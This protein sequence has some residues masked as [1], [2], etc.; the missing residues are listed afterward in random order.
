MSVIWLTGLSGAG[1]TTLGEALRRRI[2]PFAPVALLD[3]D[4]VREAVGD[5]LGHTEADR[6]VQ[7]GRLGRFA[8]LL[9]GQ[10]IVVIVA[11]V[12]AD[13]AQLAW[14]RAHL[15]GY[16]EVHLSVSLDTLARRDP[17]GLYARAFRGEARNVVGLDIPWRAPAGADLTLDLDHPEP[18]EVLASR[19][20]ALPAVAA[21]L[22]PR[23]AAGASA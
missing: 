21:A 22:E 19:V 5:D 14:N 18:V 11:A 16:A 17:R 8:R 6:V 10:G 23:T 9:A 3:G 15:P 4:A 2:A 7:V 1:K 12:Y 13:P 20:V